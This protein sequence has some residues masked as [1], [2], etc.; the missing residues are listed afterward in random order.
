M[1][2]ET[3]AQRKAGSLAIAAA[4]TWNPLDLFLRRVV[5]QR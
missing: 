2:R 5:I 3:Q 1:R 4:M